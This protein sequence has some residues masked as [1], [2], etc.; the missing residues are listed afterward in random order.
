M[1]LYATNLMGLPLYMWFIVDPDDIMRYT[2][3]F[4]KYS[5]VHENMCICE[6]LTNLLFK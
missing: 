3:V 4:L 5:I 1:V 6:Y 2:T